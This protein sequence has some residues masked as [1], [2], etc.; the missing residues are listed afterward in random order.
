MG[1]SAQSLHPVVGL[2]AR[3]RTLRDLG[4]QG[5]IGAGVEATLEAISSTSRAGA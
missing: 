1:P 2:A 4:A 3:G 5:A